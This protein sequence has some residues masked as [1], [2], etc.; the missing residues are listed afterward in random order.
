MTGQTGFTVRQAAYDLRKLRGKTL[1]VKPARSR[2]YHVPPDAAR[3]VAALLILRDH[4]IAPILAGVRNPR[5]G[6]KPTTWTQIDR[7]C[8]TLRTGMHTPFDHL[9]I[10][11]D[12]TAA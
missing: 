10:S 11:T 6:R 2:R 5:P 4:V 1:V 12:V 9:G 7:D 8:D 3:T